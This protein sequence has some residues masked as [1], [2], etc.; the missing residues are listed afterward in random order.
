MWSEDKMTTAT[1]TLD[2]VQHSI[3][4]DPMLSGLTRSS[5]PYTRKMFEERVAKSIRNGGKPFQATLSRKELTDLAHR[6]GEQYA[7]EPCGDLDRFFDIL[8][9]RWP[10]RALQTR[11][12]Q[13]FLFGPGKS[14]RASISALCTSGEGIA[15]YLME[16]FGYTPFV[17]PLGIM[18][19]LLS[20]NQSRYALT[21][22]KATTKES[23]STLRDKNLY[24]FLLDVKTRSD[25]FYYAYEAY[26]ICTQFLDGG[27]IS[28]TILHVDLADST[29]AKAPPT[30]PHP[31]A[32][33]PDDQPSQKVDTYLQLGARAARDGDRYLT[34]L[35]HDEATRAAVLTLMIEPHGDVDAQQ[36]D[37][38]LD[39]RMGD[40]KI[41]HD[42]D[43]MYERL[44]ELRE[45]RHTIV[46]GAVKKLR[47]R[48]IDWSE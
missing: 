39:R 9:N 22:A 28:C 10:P 15:G 11:S 47:K 48:E 26:L 41:S 34:E 30:G 29:S 27:I 6:Y 18:P 31:R 16:K 24:K 14:Y 38:Y 44:P 42:W 7:D 13:H 25:R 12:V 3:T 2:A 36:V 32:L 40:L 5:D 43:N 37:R 45:R 17:R 20:Y 19:D 35:L 46:A 4:L 21:E 33:P 23:P 1:Y 8:N